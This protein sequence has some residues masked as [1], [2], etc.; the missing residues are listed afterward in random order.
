MSYLGLFYPET[1]FGLYPDSDGMILFYGRI[2][3][4][5]KPGDTLLDIGCGRES[6][7]YRNDP[8]PLRRDLMMMRG[9]YARVIG[10][11]VNPEAAHNPRVDEFRPIQSDRWPIE[12]QSIDLAFSHFVLEHI[13]H[14]DQFLSECARVIKPGGMLCLR[15]TNAF[16]YVGLAS[17]LIPSRM[18]TRVLSK[19]QPERAEAD[20]YPT[21]Y[22]CNTVWALRRML[23]KHGFGDRVVYGHEGPPRYL[24][25]WFLPA[26]LG[27]LHQ[28]FAPHFMKVA[29]HA[30]AR[31]NG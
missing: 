29:L 2:R 3:A 22:R 13:E 31:R 30:Y 23:R 26:L 21:F 20:V 27:V 24:L 10:I 4:L 6:D 17:R 25:R 11:D 28:K 16:S 1:R 15:T 5:A 18:H 19:A 14:P 8:E 7:F 9:R 12:D